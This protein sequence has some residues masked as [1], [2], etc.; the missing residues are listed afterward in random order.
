MTLGKLG[1]GQKLILSF[2]ALAL[3]GALALLGML[4]QQGIPKSPLPTI[5][6]SPSATLPFRT[7]VVA[8]PQAP[9]TPVPTATDQALPTPSR[10]GAVAEI[11]AARRIEELT[12]DV[13]QIRELPRRQEIPLN[14]LSEQ[15][16]VTYLRRLLADLRQQDFV[17]RQQVLLTALDLLPAPGEAFPPTVQTRAS[18]LIAFYDPAEA[19]IFI[20]PAGRD[21]DPPDI[22][23]LH[24]YAHALID[25]HFS[26]SSFARDA[27]NADVARARDALI[28]GDAMTV[29]MMH[30][31]EDLDAS[32][33]AQALNKLALYL[34]QAE[35]TDYE[36][37]F[38]ALAMRDVFIFPYREGTRFVAALLRA[39]WW[40]AV[41]AA[42]LDP[43]V[44]TEQILHPDKYI[45]IPRDEPRTVRL[46][47]LSQDLGEGWQ[48]AAQD[49][50]GELILRAHLDVYLP[51]TSEAQSAASG[52]DG[53]LAAVWRDEDGHEVLV[54]RIVWDS[55]L[56]AVEFTHSYVTLIERRLRGAT[57]VLRPILPLNGRW[58]RGEGGNVY[59]EQTG[60]TVL[61]I[62]APDTD[63]MERAL[64]AF[65]FEE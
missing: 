45:S 22:G 49:V 52:W 35:L 58:W 40:P 13:G 60:N 1:R 10:S 61:I 15:E 63:T 7:A 33:D 6:L 12:R 42:Y 56:E 9:A 21:S 25:Q 20:G 18:Q 46:P 41:N 32:D 19:Q 31:F 16:I 5:V 36:G 30:S 51:D 14:F 27:A 34:S 3:I 64:A 24:Q 28:E 47:D 43:P 44:S 55:P 29:L 23:L 59:L 54:M 11:L 65:V 8:T 26:L 4:V 48:L 2:M 17:Q 53:D 50:L 39:D 37:Y 57:R 62:W 38:T